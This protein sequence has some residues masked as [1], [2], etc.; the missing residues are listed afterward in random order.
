MVLFSAAIKNQGGRNHVNE[1]WQ[2]YWIALFKANGYECVDLFRG[3]LWNHDAVEYWYR[4]NTFL[5]IGPQNKSLNLQMLR[6][7]QKPVFDTVHPIHY[8]EIIDYYRNKIEK[9]DLRFCLRCFRQF[10]RL[11]LRK[12]TGPAR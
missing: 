6:S 5:F 8:E 2:S 4:Q 12:I 9:P 11:E 3:A 10:I 1:Q 7:F